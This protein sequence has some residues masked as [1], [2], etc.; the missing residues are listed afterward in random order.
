MSVWRCALGAVL[1]LSTT[2]S[3]AQ[4][5]QDQWDARE[6][7]I[8]A[9]DG[10]EL[11]TVVYI[12]KDKPG[13][14][15]IIMERTPYGAGSPTRPPRRTNPKMAEAGYIFAYQD[16]RGKGK[17]QGDYVN[18]RPLLPAGQTGIDE[19]TDTFDTIEYLLKNVPKHNGSVGLWGISYPGFYA[20]AGAVRNHPALK[21]VSP[22]APVNDW[23]LG[24]DVH[25]RGA[26]FLQEMFDFMLFFDVRRGDTPPQI[27][28]MGLSAYK[29]FLQAGPPS[30]FDA[31][32]LSGKV[33]FWNEVVANDTYND[34][35]KSRALWR[36][37]HK[38][39]CAVLT[40]GGW[41]DKEDMYG[42]LKLY[43]EGE[44]QNPGISNYLVMGPWSHGQ[45][46]S[47]NGSS[48]S[49]LSFGSRTGQFYQEEIEFPFF[50]RYLRGDQ[51]AK[52]ISEVTMF[53]TGANVWHRLAQWPPR[54]ART[55]SLYLDRNKKLTWE[56]PRESGDHLYVADPAQ[57]MPYLA[58]YLTSTRAPGDWLA[59]DQSFST[60]RGDSVTFDLGTISQ[61]L[62]VAGPVVADMWIA[63]SGTDC[64]LIVKL[65]DEFP[66]DST[67]PRASG[68]GTMA[69]YQHMVRGEVIRAKFRE[70]FE[71]PIPITPGKPTRVR[72]EL[73]DVFH[74]FKAGHRIKVQ[75][76]SHWFPIVD[77]NPNTFVSRA[78]AKPEDY[79]RATI[80]VL[81]GGN[82]A[83]RLELG[84]MPPAR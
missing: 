12:P 50:E 67:E 75:V 3:F 26:L 52:P 81:T 69:G 71:R 2:F 56:A 41:Y 8:P 4:S 6:F 51:S 27:D 22:Q 36:A 45:W 7:S 31:K 57:P 78:E 39:D 42:A 79:K 70:S 33:P 82:Y 76:Q 21:A 15:P 24:D 74:T 23:F 28:R 55:R 44:V 61:D 73:N 59:R 16:V 49:D 17:S 53:E 29:F 46:A 64:D 40:V 60:R 25:H 34:F 5:W 77:R 20:G 80:R 58:D 68:D 63:T 72:L 9:R 10:T 35:W 14:F 38:V 37:F 18:V 30:Q 47:G 48:L 19:S 84:V 65:I 11:Y 83:S 1:A 43:R 13:P 54:E 62:R 32:Y 66:A